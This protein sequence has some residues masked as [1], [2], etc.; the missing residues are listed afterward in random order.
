MI[1]AEPILQNCLVT[2]P[3]GI[4]NIVMEVFISDT[5]GNNTIYDPNLGIIELHNGYLEYVILNESHDY[6]SEVEEPYEEAVEALKN[7]KP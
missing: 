2:R 5:E 4:K 6:V 7:Q 3:L 1:N